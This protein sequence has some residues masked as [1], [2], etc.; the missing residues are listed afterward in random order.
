[1]GVAASMKEVAA[2][3]E[4]GA[5]GDRDAF[6]AKY[7]FDGTSLIAE[8]NCGKVYACANK[9]TSEACAVKCISMAGMDTFAHEELRNEVH[10]LKCAAHPGIVKLH[11]YYEDAAAAEAYVVTELLEGGEVFDQLIDMECYAEKDARAVVAAVV[12]VLVALHGAGRG[13]TSARHSPLQ[14]LRSRPSSTRAGVA[15][16]DV[17]LSN[18][19]LKTPKD[20]TS[21]KLCDF[22]FAV[23][24]S[25]EALLKYACGSPLYLA[26]EIVHRAPPYGTPVDVWAVGVAA[27]ILL[28]GEPPFDADADY[29]DEVL[30]SIKAGTRA[31]QE[32]EIPNFKGSDLGHFPLAHTEVATAHLEKTVASFRKNKDSFRGKKR[33]KASATKLR[34]TLRASR[35]SFAKLDAAAAAI[36]A[37]EAL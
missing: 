6:L 22:G 9:E 24:E 25:N 28:S 36:P 8:G 31:A 13:G 14:R 10:L 23:H 32:S 30:E 26:P 11:D 3:C 5:V 7:D 16:R 1:M 4:G 20:Q 33:L 18:F 35:P 37:I 15:H 2:Y 27:Y 34:N 19:V 21:L 29:E 12:D 17:E